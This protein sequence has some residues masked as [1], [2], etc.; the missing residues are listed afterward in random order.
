MG[1]YHTAPSF[2]D[3]QNQPPPP[4]NHDSQRIG[5][6][7]RLE[8]N[9]MAMFLKRRHSHPWPKIG[10]VHCRIRKR[11]TCQEQ[12]STWNKSI[13]SAQEALVND[14]QKH[15]LTRGSHLGN[16][17]VNIPKHSLLSDNHSKSRKKECSSD[18]PYL[19]ADP[20]LYKPQILSEELHRLLL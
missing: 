18:S 2:L 17:N 14:C 5:I 13:S 16:I 15:P 4:I 1:F 3:A 10:W 20:T 11:P 9:I 8:P 12:Q 19:L 7:L 6:Q